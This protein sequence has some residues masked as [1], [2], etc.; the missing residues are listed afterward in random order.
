M[1]D[2]GSEAIELLAPVEP[3][4][5]LEERVLLVDDDEVALLL[6][7]AAAVDLVDEDED[8]VE[9]GEEEVER[10][11]EEVERGEEEVEREEVE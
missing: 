11:E 8:E 10:G 7:V 4:D 9:R 6:G 3:L 2:N 1:T 5:V